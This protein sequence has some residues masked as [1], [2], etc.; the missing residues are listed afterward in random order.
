MNPWAYEKFHWEDEY[1]GITWQIDA[2]GIFY[3]KDIF[4]E[5]GIPVPTNWD[6][7]LEA[8]KALND[9]ENRGSTESHSQAKQEPMTLTSSS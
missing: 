2:R 8:A 6:E 9:P 1:I 4:E 7:L 3:R 5:K